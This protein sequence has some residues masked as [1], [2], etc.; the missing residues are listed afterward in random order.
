MLSWDF[1]LLTSLLEACNAGLCGSMANV[2]DSNNPDPVQS[3]T[4]SYNI[5]SKHSLEEET[6]P[7]QSKER[8]HK[9]KQNKTLDSI[10]TTAPKPKEQMFDRGNAI[11]AY[12]K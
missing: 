12:Y 11:K 7:R 2:M 8:Q 6:P 1:L 5:L 4:P 3:P 9:P 10:D